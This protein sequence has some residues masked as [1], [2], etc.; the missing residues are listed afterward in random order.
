MLQGKK[1]WLFLAHFEIIAP[2]TLRDT[3]S[4]PTKM[5]LVVLIAAAQPGLVETDQD[6][7]G[8]IDSHTSTCCRAGQ[9][10]IPLGFGQNRTYTPYIWW[11]PCHKIP[12]IH[13][14]YMVLANPAYFWYDCSAF[15]WEA[16][17]CTAKML[18][19]CRSS[20]FN[21]DICASRKAKICMRRT[22]SCGNLDRSIHL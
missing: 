19:K 7:I 8:S 22:F 10:H 15:G 16:S 4:K 13:R 6:G 3:W 9:D 2:S 11:F 12:C 20:H 1:G 18:F 14:I 17:Y 5:A 21:K